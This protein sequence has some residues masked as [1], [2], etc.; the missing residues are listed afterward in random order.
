MTLYRKIL[1][2][3]L[4]LS[5]KNKYLW[6]YGL[7]AAIIVGGEY[8]I[9]TKSLSGGQ[10]IIDNF[11]T[12]AS[13]NILSGQTFLTLKSLMLENPAT[14]MV[15]IFVGLLLIALALFL[16]WVMITS[17][18]ALVNNSA[19]ILTGK[20][21]QFNDGIQSGIK[22][23]WPVLGYN[24]ITKLV[25]YLGLIL[26]SL[27]VIFSAGKLSVVGSN[28]IYLIAF[29]VFLPIIIA[30]S[31]IFKYAIAY[32]VIKERS[33]M[34]SI[35]AGWDLFMANWLVSLEMA[36][37]LFF[38]SFVVTILTALAWYVLAIP[39]IFFAVLANYIA[40]ATSFWLLYIFPRVLYFLI[41]AYVG[42]LLATYQVSAWTGL[43]IE[44][45]GKGA[46]SKLVRIFKNIGTK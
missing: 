8:D 12:I 44:L 21:H 4:S 18:T 23:F 37:I 31:F 34:E 16:I 13:T 39:A 33:F 42:A 30:L 25:I 19:N 22:H 17:E 29:I 3:A 7:F 45:I 38:I 11:K 6:F 10:E 2:Q 40:P 1:K 14:F 27:P 24:L 41:I 32:R 5:W 35:R 15:T 26:I 43:F 20:K 36:F 9:I 46:T 28:F